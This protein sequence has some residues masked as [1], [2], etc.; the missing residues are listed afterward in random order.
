MTSTKKVAL[1][2]K[3]LHQIIGR[4]LHYLPTK[5]VNYLR[6]HVDALEDL[7]DRADC[8]DYFGTEG[9]RHHLGFVDD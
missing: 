3:R 8:D 1:S 5:D 2:T 9:W 4:C 6:E 7:L